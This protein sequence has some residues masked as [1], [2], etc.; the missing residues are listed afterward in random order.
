MENASNYTEV[1]KNKMI[2]KEFSKFKK[3]YKE[4]AK[5]KLYYILCKMLLL[6]L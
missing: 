4:L 5:K 6:C 2:K 3:T 1:E